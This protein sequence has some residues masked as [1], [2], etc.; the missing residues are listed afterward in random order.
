MTFV[1]REGK[2]IEVV[3]LTPP[4]SKQP[5]RKHDRHIGCP[6]A[7]L[8]RV[9]PVARSGEQLALALWLYR[10]HKVSG[11]PV[12]KAPN[13]ELYDDLG[14]TRFAKYRALRRFEKVGMVRRLKTGPKDTSIELIW[15]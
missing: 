11:S 1:M 8:R 10:R 5:K 14:L 4:T 13:A 9:L 15:T 7:W 3:P 12:F 6:T 2:R